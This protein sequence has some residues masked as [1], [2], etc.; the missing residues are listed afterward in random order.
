MISFRLKVIFLMAILL[1]VFMSGTLISANQKGVKPDPEMRLEWYQKHVDMKEKSLF[2]NLAW[3]LLGPLNISGRMTDVE[4]VSPKGKHYTI[5]VAG[6]SGGVWKTDNE[7]VTWE[8]IFEHAASTS[9]GDLAIAPSNQKIIWVGTGEAN[10]F[11]SSM[12][13]CGVYKSVDG[14]KTWQHMGLVDTHT[15]ARIIIHPKNPDI[16][17]VAA[18]GHEWTDNTER[19]VYKTTDG[20]KTWSK[21]LY[22]NEKTGAID[23]VMD[24]SDSNTIYAV[25]WQRVRKKWNDPRNEPNYSGSGIFKSTD[26]GKNWLEINSGLPLPKHRGRIGIDLCRSKP[27]VLYAFV[28]NYEVVG[29]WEEGETDSYGRPKGGMIKGATVYRSD[30]KGK[31]WIQ[32]SQENDFMRRLSATYGWVFGQ[33]RVDPNDENKIYVM[34]LALNVSEDSGKTFRRL[35]GMHG[36][37]HGLWI[38]PDNSDYLVN[39]ND[40]GVAISYDGGDNWRT[41]YDNLPLV[42][43]FNVMYDMDDPFHVYGSIQD[44]GS[45]KGVV[46]LSK[47]RH[48]IPAVKWDNAPGGEGS[49]HAI[50]PTNPNI[51]Y[52]AGFYGTISRTDIGTGKR[53]NLVPKPLKGEATYRGQWVAPFIISP[54]NPRIIYHGLNF[55][56]RSLD[57]GENFKKIS[58]DLTYNDKNKMGDIPYQTLFAISESPLRFGLIYAGTDDGR[59]HVTKNSGKNWMEITRGLVKGRWISRIA[60]SAFDLGTVYVSQNGKRDDDFKAY[61]W[62]STNF[63]KTWQNITANIPCGPVNVIREDPKNKNVLYVGTDIGAYVSIN[64]G[65]TWHVLSKDFPST[66]VH[67][68]V[69]HPRESLLI[70]ATHGRGMWAMDVSKIQ[71]L[72]TELLKKATHLFNTCPAKLPRRTWRRWAGGQNAFVQYYLKNAQPVKLIIKDESGNVVKEIKGTGDAGLNIVEWNL[73]KADE[74]FVKAGKYSVV[75]VAGTVTE[76]GTLVVKK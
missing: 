57:R 32:V 4:V 27:N 58:P 15:I 7:G 55:L 19:G 49:S 66:F 21:I 11:R 28:D 75:L 22:I 48:N 35:P 37:H 70:A 73:Q 25:T 34:G 8:P 54:H 53:K 14:G 39:V 5:Y 45:Y 64:G 41:F 76:K 20:G 65:R 60:A 30:D 13:G 24:P 9:I 50:D 74:K 46:D 12:A 2:K 26:A 17:Y 40:G 51:V 10:I 69:I 43:F 1:L 23:L 59:I 63:G 36:D 44:H 52:S 61:I 71:K 62:K 72:T 33:M 38:D 6:A 42:Q 3:Q 56:F 68:L 29:E 18:S 47:G 67:D 31:S 16:V